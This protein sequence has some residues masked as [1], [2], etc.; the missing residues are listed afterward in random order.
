MRPSVPSNQLDSVTWPRYTPKFVDDA[1]P[2]K[3]E[4]RASERSELR[5]GAERCEP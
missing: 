4:E 2:L 1:H 3:Y 5:P